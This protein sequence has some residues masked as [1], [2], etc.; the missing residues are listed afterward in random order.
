MFGTSRA[1]FGC[2]SCREGRASGIWGRGHVR[3]GTPCRMAHDGVVGSKPDSALNGKG[4][5]THATTRMSPAGTTLS[6]IGQ[7][8]TDRCRVVPGSSHPG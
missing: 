7:A 1:T 5:V 2:H 8:G 6:E 3:S 4:A